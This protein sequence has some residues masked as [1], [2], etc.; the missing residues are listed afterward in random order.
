MEVKVNNKCCVIIGSYNC[1]ETIYQ[2]LLS[3]HRSFDGVSYH[4]VYF[5]DESTDESVKIIESFFSFRNVSCVRCQVNKEWTIS[6]KFYAAIECA[7][8]I[9]QSEIFFF[10][11]GD[12]LWDDHKVNCTIKMFEETNAGLL[13]SGTKEFGVRASIITPKLS[14]FIILDFLFNVSPGMSFAVSR[15]NLISY[16][17][18][19]GRQ[20]KWHDHGIFIFSKYVKKNVVTTEN[21]LQFYRRHSGQFTSRNQLRYFKRLSYGVQNFIVLT[22]IQLKSLKENRE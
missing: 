5:D 12:D 18:N 17:R 9:D 4:C 2:Q 3:I 14:R 8:E 16:L 20:F 22:L 13:L 11:D 21:I 6:K 7:L 19:G 15:D 10:A 1:S